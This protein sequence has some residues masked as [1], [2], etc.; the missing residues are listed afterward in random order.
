VVTTFDRKVYFDNVREAPFAGSLT[1][2]QVDGQSFI[3]NAWEKYVP[4][5]DVRWLAYFLATAF[6]ETSQA[7]WPVEEYDKGKGQPYGAV[8]PM[9]GQAYYGR[10]F[11]Q[12]TWK[13]NYQRADDELGLNPSCV[14]DPS[15]QL[16]PTI[17]ARTGYRGMVEGW[18]RA[19]NQFDTFFND[20]IDDPYGAREI[21]NGD[22][23]T[24]PTWSNGES[25]GRMVAG[26]HAAFLSALA[27]AAN[28]QPSRDTP[29][30]EIT[31]HGDV[32]VIVNGERVV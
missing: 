19:P 9:T 12:L 16:D 20:M 14:Q 29:I 31:V 11:V 28:D 13:S 24:V 27:V 26:Y 4:D 25:I 17:S 30:V 32:Q 15:Q 1:Q 21:V 2:R 23:T 8:D 5:Q 18:F 6:H 10:G 7:M 3:L 22:K